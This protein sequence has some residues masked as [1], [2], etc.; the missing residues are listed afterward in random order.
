YTPLIMYGY[1]S[2]G[3]N[4]DRTDILGS[5]TQWD[6]ERVTASQQTGSKGQV[7]QYGLDYLNLNFT[8]PF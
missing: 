4:E 7:R 2:V 3:Y 6:N 5:M 8:L 1:F